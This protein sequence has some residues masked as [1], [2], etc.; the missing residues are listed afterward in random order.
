MGGL[1]TFLAAK[2]TKMLFDVMLTT[3]LQLNHSEYRRQ[4]LSEVTL[5]SIKGKAWG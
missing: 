2:D 5:E 4:I 1:F 3:R